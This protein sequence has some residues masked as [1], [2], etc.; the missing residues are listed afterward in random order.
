MS[1]SL[2][3]LLV[4]GLALLVVGADLLIRGAA[5][6]GAAL[7]I[8]PLVIGL[9]VVAFGTSAPELAV[10]LQAA[11][12]GRSDISIGGV[13]GSNVFNVLAIL[14]LA[15]VV[16][17]L[18]VHRKV[19]RFDVPLMILASA[20]AWLLASD[21]R[22]ERLDGALLLTGVV[23]YTTWSIRAG[24]AEGK[25]LVGGARP[26]RAPRAVARNVIL[27][28]GGL[29]LLVLGARLLVDAATATARALGLSELVIGLTVVGSGTS[30]P[31]L[32]TSLVAA[33]R[34]ERDLAVGNVVGSNIFNVLCVLGGASLLSPSGIEVAPTA[35]AFDLPVMT[36]VA[37][38]CLPVFLT[39]HVIARW[40]GFLFLLY[41]VAYTTWLILAAVGSAA[42]PTFRGA[43]FGFVLPLTLVTLTVTTVR[44]TRRKK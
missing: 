29:V 9:T 26:V 2:L 35:L 13:V 25:A 41:Y 8:P 28:V 39:G 30:P 34:G 33:L 37:F 31:E 42:L 15:A 7:G 12:S 22:L 32:A 11:A 40:E 1:I 5:R 44:W 10:S 24:R 38:A 23:A 20:I 27:V 19:I 21:G 3:G 36:A 6:L 4:L 17:P 43:M 16:A 18:T 14:G